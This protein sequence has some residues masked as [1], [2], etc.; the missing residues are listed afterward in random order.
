MGVHIMAEHSSELRYAIKEQKWL[1][2][3]W[4]DAADLRDIVGGEKGA[5]FW[6]PW[7]VLMPATV[8]ILPNLFEG[9]LLLAW[10]VLFFAVPI[11]LYTFADKAMRNIGDKRTALLLLHKQKLSRQEFKLLE[12][13]SVFGPGQDD[14][15]HQE[16]EQMQKVF[17]RKGILTRARY[18][19]QVLIGDPIKV[20]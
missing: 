15:L 16:I 19:M 12:H 20:P 1:Y 14:P 3:I 17:D 18:L 8:A 13:W 7:V 9:W 10:V 4:G 5:F 11:L 6:G 2:F